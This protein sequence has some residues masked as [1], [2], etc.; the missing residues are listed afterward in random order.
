MVKKQATASFTIF[1][2]GKNAFTL[3]EVLITLSIIGIVSA[4]TIPTL[5]TNYQ[6]KSWNTSATVFER[7]LEEALKVMNTQQVLAGYTTTEAFVNELSRHFKTT[8]TCDNTKLK[9]CFNTSVT[10]RKNPVKVDLTNVSTSADLGQSSW[11]T[12]I[13]GAQFANGTTALIAYNPKC[14]QDPLSNQVTGGDCL[15]ILYDTSGYKSP[16]HLSKDLR[17]NGHVKKIGDKGLCAVE[18]GDSCYGQIFT[19]TPITQA[20]CLELK[21]NGYGMN[22]CFSDNDYW[23][24]A[25][26]TCGGT[27]NL[28]SVSDLASLAEGICND[29]SSNYC[30]SWNSE[31]GEALGFDLNLDVNQFW[32]KTEHITNV[33]EFQNGADCWYFYTGRYA[34]EG[35]ASRTKSTY[36]AMCKMQ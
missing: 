26:K 8:K 10:M 24:G 3:A 23:A 17:A 35:I 32:A 33:V 21:A 1:E 7:K 34:G 13:V 36:K 19:P 28:P 15:A 31:K 16:N 11:N 25:V 5:V 20:E 14:K 18:V 22:N 27:Q 30:P 6:E 9:D 4:M 29:F 12:N 2:S